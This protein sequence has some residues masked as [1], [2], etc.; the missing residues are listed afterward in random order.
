MPVGIDTGCQVI[1]LEP[2]PEA[3]IGDFQDSVDPNKIY[4]YKVAGIDFSGN[5]SSLENTVPVSTFT[6]ST[7]HATPKWEIS[8]V[9]NEMPCG[10]KISWLPE[11]NP[12]SIQGFA[13]FRATKKE[14]PFIQRGS[15]L[16][17]NS[18]ID[19]DVITNKKY[20]YRI[21]LYDT[22]SRASEPSYYEEGTII[23]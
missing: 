21:L 8:V 15:I 22:E 18:F 5:E 12:K 16:T 1:P 20:Y 9:Q 13:V 14:G 2:W 6:F 17:T 10:L 3:S 4:W 23:R 7:A 11:F 19:T